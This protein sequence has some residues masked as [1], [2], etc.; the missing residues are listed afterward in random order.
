M[1]Y[2]YQG[3]RHEARWRDLLAPLIDPDGRERKFVELGCNAGFYLRKAVELNYEHI[4]GIERDPEF[5]RQALE[6]EAPVRIVQADIHEWE[7]P[8]CHTALLACVHYWQT[9]DQIKNL[10]G[11]LRRKA[12]HLVV[13][14]KHRGQSL[15]PPD[16]S[17]FLR[18]LRG[19]DVIDQ[20]R[21]SR[22]W[23]L[24]LKNRNL[25]EAD[26][27]ELYASQ[28]EAIDWTDD[29]KD[30][31]P[32]FEDYVGLVLSGQYFD[33]RRTRFARYLKTRKFRY[34]ELMLQAYRDMVYS[35]QHDGILSPLVVYER[36]RVLNG[37]HRLAIA[38]LTGIKKVICC[39]G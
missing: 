4:I 10:L 11:R 14:G 2:I 9:D 7:I 35:V 1:T 19:W 26:V 21:T 20:R 31:F 24:L 16:R 32:A 22:H 37:N 34:R 6:F 30:F 23:S 15:T 27:E 18:K 38:H 13:M 5:V 39:H 17:S 28:R 29:G 8:A 25:Y 36:R 3:P 33:P 12:L